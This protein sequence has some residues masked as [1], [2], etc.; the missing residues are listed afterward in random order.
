MLKFSEVQQ[1]NSKDSCWV[2]VHGKAYDLTEFLPDHPGGAGIILK[3]AGKDATEEYDPIHPP[4]TLE[5]NLAKEKCLGPVDPS[6]ITKEIKNESDP[7]KQLAKQKDHGAIPPLS[8]CLNLYDFEVI[9][10]RVL[11]PTAWA[12]YSSGADDEVTMRENTSAFARIWFRPR[13]LRDVS[14]IDYSTSIL[15][16]KSTLPVYI[17]ATALGKLGHPDGEKNLTVAAGKQGIIQMIPTLASCSLDE[18][19]GARVN[20]QQVQFMQLYVNSNRS[21]TEKIIAK[22]EAAGVKALFVTVDAPQLG[23]REKDMRMKFDDVGS[24]MQ[25]KNKD[26]VDRS[27]GAARAISSFID[28]SLSW[29]DLTWLRSLTR[30]PIV[31]KGVQTWQDALRAAQLGLSGVVLSNHG[32][33]QLDFARS[34]IEVLA[35]VVEAFKARGLFPNPMFQ[36]FVDGGIR[37]ASDVLK[38]LAIGA[39]AVGIGRP[40][41]YAYSAYASDGV[42]H[43]I[44]LLKAEMEMNMRL[45]G[46]ATLKDVVPEMVDARALATHVNFTPPSHGHQIYEKLH[47]AVGMPGEPSNKL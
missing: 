39:T 21:I 23:R 11:K 26:N 22:A 30:M 43:A 17:T 46:A 24:D 47:T 28:P 12:Y 1:H 29:D 10:K 36:I 31:L 2:V 45:L 4:G 35:E 37:R 18:I 16:H 13:I 41:L 5:E 32:G 8:Q 38:A 15:G 20:E 6:T 25:N 19:I 40:F 27:Q 34:G 33:R 7:A 9:A 42:V 14:K 3:Y 44:Q